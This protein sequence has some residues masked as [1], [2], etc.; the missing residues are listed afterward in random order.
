MPPSLFFCG[1]FGSLYLSL[2]CPLWELF[3]CPLLGTFI[4]VLFVIFSSLLGQHSIYYK[5]EED[6][7]TFTRYSYKNRNYIMMYAN[8][9]SASVAGCTMILAYH[10]AIIRAKPNYDAALRSSKSM[11]ENERSSHE[12]MDVVWQYILER[13]L[14]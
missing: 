1:L 11:Y 10:V 9:C 8:V 3:K 6:Q 14:K 12:K 7:H 2:I 5:D 13:L 4:C